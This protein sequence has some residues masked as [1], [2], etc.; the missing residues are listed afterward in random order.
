MNAVAKTGG[1]LV[2][3]LLDGAAQLR[4]ELFDLFL[5]SDLAVNPGRHLAAM[6]DGTVLDLL[7][8]LYQLALEY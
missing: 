2:Q 6:L 4:P 3:L 5:A 1:M 7:Q 8:E